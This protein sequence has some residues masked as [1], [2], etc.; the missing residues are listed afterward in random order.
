MGLYSADKGKGATLVDERLAGL[1]SKEDRARYYEEKAQ[2][3]A[4]ASHNSPN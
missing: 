1:G 4:T 3:A 2:Q